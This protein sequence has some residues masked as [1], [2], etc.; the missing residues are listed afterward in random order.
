MIGIA[1]LFA[2]SLLPATPPPNVG[3]VADGRPVA[4]ERKLHG[5]WKGGACVGVLTL[6]ANG[7][8]ERRH[9]SPGN[10]MLTGTWEVR[11]DALPPTLTLTCKDADFAG[12]VGTTQAVKLVHLDDDILAWKFADDK[13]LVRFERRKK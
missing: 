13:H 10:N 2:A 4:L 8:F 11:W 3:G 12:Y 5:T 1:A 9:Y 6:R 7:T